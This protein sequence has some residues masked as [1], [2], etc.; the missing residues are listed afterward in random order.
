M[1][2]WLGEV[3]H[4]L[5]NDRLILRLN[6]SLIQPKNHDQVIKT[7][8]LEQLISKPVVDENMKVK[9][10]ILEIFG[11]VKTPYIMVKLNDPPKE[12][13]RILEQKFYLRDG[14]N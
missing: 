6:E 9:G 5:A 10:T 12:D 11:P 2:R 4:I 8:D 7:K 14:E 1:I 13:E 3:L